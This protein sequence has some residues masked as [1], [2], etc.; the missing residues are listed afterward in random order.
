MTSTDLARQRFSSGRDRWLTW[1]SYE[2]INCELVVSW[3]RNTLGDGCNGGNINA[4]ANQFYWFRFLEEDFWLEGKTKGQLAVA[5]CCWVWYYIIFVK[6]VC[7]LECRLTS[8]SVREVGMCLLIV[9]C[10]CCSL[11]SQRGI[12]YSEQK[13]KMC[14]RTFSSNDHLSDRLVSKRILC[15]SQG[16][17]TFK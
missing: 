11:S 7:L 13:S 2:P 3:F 10:H 15:S 14:H 6:F 16:A 9:S 1:R 5:F 17:V 8:H 4:F 12:S